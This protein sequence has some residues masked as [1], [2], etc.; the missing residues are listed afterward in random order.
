MTT[1][2][3]F[4]NGFMRLRLNLPAV[5]C[6][7]VVFVLLLGGCSTRSIKGDSYRLQTPAFD[8]EG[9][10][11]GSVKAWGI[12]QD[13]NGDVIQ[14]FTVE[15]EGS[16]NGDSVVLDEV[17]DYD[18]G[19]GPATRRW[20]LQRVGQDKWV[21]SANDIAS[22]A[23]GTQHGNAFNWNYEM[24]LPRKGSDKTVRVVFDDWLW[25]MDGNTVV[26]RS[27]IRK[28]GITFAEVTIFMQKQ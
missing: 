25:A 11:A 20:E 15:I 23:T 17:F 19:E 26:N 22:A 13:R 2:L 9:F 18:F 6:T 21:G 28:F 14:R 24:D 3:N 16:V 1:S 27:Y 4:D 7:A 10:F 8:I 12:V 5:L